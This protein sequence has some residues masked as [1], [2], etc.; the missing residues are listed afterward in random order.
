MIYY[1]KIPNVLHLKTK[2]LPGSNFGNEWNHILDK[3]LPKPQVY[4]NAQEY[5]SE[6]SIQ[7]IYK[8]AETTFKKIGF[9]GFGTNFWEN[10]VFNMTFCE[11]QIISFCSDEHTE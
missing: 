10:S 7:D 11:S 5:F 2:I 8:M 4:Y 1:I 6:K 3:V 9:K